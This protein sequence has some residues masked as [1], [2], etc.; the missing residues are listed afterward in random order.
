[1][2]NKH[3]T[4]PLERGV[5]GGRSPP[6]FFGKFTYFPTNSTSNTF[7]FGSFIVL[8][9][10]SFWVAPP[11]LTKLQRP[12]LINSNNTPQAVE[13]ASKPKRALSY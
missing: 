8:R 5:Q 13:C 4:G 7:K 6:Q 9:P 3:F 12:C 11:V 1:M 10:P 2:P